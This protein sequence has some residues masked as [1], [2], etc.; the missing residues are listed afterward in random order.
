VLDPPGAGA[1]AWGAA[2][3]FVSCLAVFAGAWLAMRDE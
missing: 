1:R 2:A 3:G